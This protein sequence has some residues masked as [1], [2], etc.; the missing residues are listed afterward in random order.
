MMNEIKAV[1]FDWAGTTIDYGC[2]APVKGFIDGYKSIGIEITTE[3]ARK[4]MGLLKFDHTKEIAKML[5]TPVSEEDVL[6]AY[7]KF[8]EI[9]FANIEDHCDIKDYVVETVE[10][11]RSRGIKIGSSTGYTTE[12]MKK[13]IPKV[14]EQGYYPDFYISPDQASKGRPYPYMIWENIKNFEIINPRLVVKV[15]DT[16]SDI[17]EGINAGC[18]TVGV[19]MGSS[20]LGLTREEVSSLS[21]QELNEKKAAVREVYNNAGANYVIDDLNELVGVIDDINSKLM[22]SA[23]NC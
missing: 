8:E 11:L 13:V 5:D 23:Q 7:A 15:G 20:E 14:K 1:I 22:G 18:W 21:H 4:P 19:I 17:D 9:L 2:F 12:M 10:T 16:T 3:M 6:K